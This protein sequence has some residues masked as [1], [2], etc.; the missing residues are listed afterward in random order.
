MVFP[1]LFSDEARQQ[2]SLGLRPM[3]CQLISCDTGIV[4]GFPSFSLF[5]KPP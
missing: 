4:D 1:S 2:S 5:T 3:L